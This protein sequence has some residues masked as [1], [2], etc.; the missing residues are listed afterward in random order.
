MVFAARRADA[1]DLGHK[2]PGLI[3]LD[4]GR[5]LN[6]T[7]QAIDRVVCKYEADQ[8]RD[9]RGNR[10]PVGDLGLLGI[11][12]AA[13]LSHICSSEARDRLPQPSP[14]R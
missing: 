8:V 13:G 11:S 3:G 10:I 5:I 6:P 2:L 14:R 4:A 12:N 9:R 7:A 1:Q